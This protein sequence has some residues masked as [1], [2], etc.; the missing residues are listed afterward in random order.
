MA[1]DIETMSFEIRGLYVATTMGLYDFNST[2]NF[3]VH[4][5]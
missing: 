2:R 5:V 3:L 1:M 4:H